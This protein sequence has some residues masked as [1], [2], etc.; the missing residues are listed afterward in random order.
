MQNRIKAILESCYLVN[1]PHVAVD[2]NQRQV[3]LG[4]LVEMQR[5]IHVWLALQVLGPPFVD[6]PG[7]WKKKEKEKKEKWHLHLYCYLKR[8]CM[9]L[10][11][12]AS[13]EK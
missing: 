2:S 3:V 7:F 11:F 6:V 4:T 5:W 13:T 1:V 12:R 10:H 9:L 8:T